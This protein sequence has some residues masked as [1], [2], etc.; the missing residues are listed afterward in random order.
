MGLKEEI[1]KLYKKNAILQQQLR[2]TE[3]TIKLVK[4][5]NIDALVD[6]E[7]KSVKV[8]T[9]NTADKTYRILIEK[10]HEGAVTL[11][12][13]GIILYCNSCFASMINTPLQ[14]IIGTLLKDFIVNASK[15]NFDTVIKKGWEG[16][17]NEEIYLK[18]ND[19]KVLPVLMSIN[20]FELD[21]NFVLSI[22]L[23]DLTNQNKNKEELKLRATQLEQNNIELESAIKELAFQ[24]EEKEKRAT[25]LKMANKELAFQKEEKEKRAAELRIANYARGIIEASLDPLVT[26]NTEGKITDVNVATV[27]IT[28][29][30]REKLKGT[31]FFSYFTEPQKGR[32]VYQEVFAK[33]SVIDFPL[34]LCH[35]SGKLTDVLF[36]GSVYKDDKGDV[37]GVVIVARDVTD[38]KRIESELIESKVLAELATLTAEEAK[39]KA[40]EATR[41]AEDAVKAKQQFLSNMSHEIRTPMNAII[42]FTR[43]LLKTEL[44][45]KQIEYL[46]AIQLSGDTLIA[47]INDILDLAKVNAGK[48]IFEKK[49]FEMAVSIDSMLQLFETKIQEKNLKL[50]TK[51]DK[52]IPEVLLGDSIRLHQ[53]ILNLVSNAVK[54]TV[55]G[56]IV[57]STNLLFEDADKV[58]VEFVIADSGIG[59]PEDNID[60][61]FENFQQ[62]SNGSSIHYGGTGLGLAIVKQLVTSQGGSIRVKSKIN[63]GST[64]SFTLPFHKT[65]EGTETETDLIESNTVVKNIKVLVVEDM[66]LNQLL[67]KTILAD[68]GF[69]CEIADNGKI[70]IEKLEK[71]SY[72]IILMDLQMPVM[73][74]LE[75]TK[76]IR[77]IM[78]LDIPIIALTAD[79]TTVDLGKCKAAE[80]NDYLAKPIDEKLLYSK[81]VELIK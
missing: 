26:I 75:A 45:T 11:N 20:T 56:T 69:D 78:K 14:K 57:F 60:L 73:N 15:V 61:I 27:K 80:I 38:Q 62:A 70:A 7:K 39:V 28:G 74:G 79:V 34:T 72:D 21:N 58:I 43:V 4:T 5:G 12:D 19:R 13:D 68:F 44:T 10:M 63:E 65:K 1:E 51:L 47:L 6:S 41:A 36:N 9:E 53:I 31:N 29:I 48:M 55:Q 33:G 42:G 17:I 77:E 24:N 37:L 8:Y 22:I 18:V 40:E 71:K 67:M 23:T 76:H 30:T 50:V 66:P 49:S 32:E 59:I 2:E 64:F 25:E 46:S 35:K 81:I 16:K 52:K 54:F 3:E